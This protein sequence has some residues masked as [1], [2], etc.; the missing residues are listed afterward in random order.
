MDYRTLFQ[1]GRRTGR[2]HRMVTDAVEAARR[3]ESVLILGAYPS[4]C[5][6]LREMVCEVA[7][8][9]V[10]S[11]R[12]AGGVVYL[13]G[14]GLVAVRLPVGNA[15]MR[16]GA[17]QGGHDRTFADHHTVEVECGWAIGQWL[18][19]ANPFAATETPPDGT[20]PGRG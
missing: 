16:D 2:T 7:G 10:E 15:S 9:D 5:D 19:Y 14:G 1:M 11:K 20:R 8:D 3:G 13:R 18:T 4:H 6:R 12:P 17:A